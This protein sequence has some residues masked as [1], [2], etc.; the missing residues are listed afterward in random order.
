MKFTVDQIRQAVDVEFTSD[1]RKEIGGMLFDTINREDM[2]DLLGEA[3]KGIQKDAATI[4]SV[5]AE[6][7]KWNTMDKILWG[8][9]IAY[10][11]G[12]LHGMNMQIK[13][14]ANAIAEL[15]KI[16]A[17]PAEGDHDYK[18]F[19]DL[20]AEIE[21]VENTIVMV[22]DQTDD[23][24]VESVLFGLQRHLDQIKRDLSELELHCTME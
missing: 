12:M 5:E 10:V 9:K 18:D 2:T 1:D 21:A 22:Q 13:A 11:Q 14:N 19:D 3:I 16:A 17:E 20:Y 15:E 8:V 7:S 4:P 23:N 6:V 24:A